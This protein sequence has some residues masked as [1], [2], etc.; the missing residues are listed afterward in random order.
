MVKMTKMNKKATCKAILANAKGA[1]S[2]KAML[3]ALEMAFEA[4]YDDGYA[5]AATSGWSANYQ[6]PPRR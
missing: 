3:N 6:S 5:K 1:L 2:D 4:G